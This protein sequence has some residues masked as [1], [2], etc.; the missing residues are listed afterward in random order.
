MWPALFLCTALAVAQPADVPAEAAP[1]LSLPGINLPAQWKNS[2]QAWKA[3]EQEL[4]IQAGKQTDW[5]ISPID[6]KA[7]AT[8]PVALFEPASDFVLS[9]RVRLDA[10]KQ[11]E[12]GFLMAYENDATWAKL[13]LE[14]SAYNEPTTVSVVTRGVSDD[15]NSAIVPGN[16]I[17]LQIAKSGPALFF[18]SSP[19]GRA[20]RL[21]RAFRLGSAGRLLTG[22]GA[23]SPLGDRGTAVFSEIKYSARKISDVFKGQ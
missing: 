10:P 12:A 22:F 18:Y 7:S 6:E 21:V 2:P 9:A 16:S 3:A 17:Y 23:Q 8:A 1:A 5:F 20:W 15:C 11:W 14:V 4:T 13:A 19:D